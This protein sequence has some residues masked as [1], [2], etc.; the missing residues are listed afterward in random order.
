MNALI[1]TGLLLDYLRG[2]ERA[3]RALHDCTHRAITVAT[4]L[5]V[6]RASPPDRREAT[7]SFLRTFERLSISESS[8]DEAVRL[9]FAH[10]GLSAARAINWANAVVNQLVF[11]TTDPGGGGLP[12]RDVVVPYVGDGRAPPGV[13]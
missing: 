9:S 12:N 2:D 1:D 7:R 5:E 10:P 11:V 8:A 13:A 6:M 3:A 4:W